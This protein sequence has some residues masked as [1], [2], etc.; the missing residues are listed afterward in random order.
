MFLYYPKGIQKNGEAITY[1]YGY[2][3]FDIS[4]MPSFSTMRCGFSEGY[5]AIIAIANL[6]GGFVVTI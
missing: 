6:R 3:G 4:L 2:G 5:N 1:L